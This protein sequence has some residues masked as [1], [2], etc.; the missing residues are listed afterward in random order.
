M[1]ERTGYEAVLGQ[2]RPIAVLTG[3]VVSQRVH[4]AYL[5]TGPDGVGKKRVA[6]AFAQALNCVGG[7]AETGVPC[8]VCRPCQKITQGIH[9]D[10]SMI[11]PD[12]TKARWVVKIDAVREITRQVTFKPY[13]GRRRVVMIDDAHTVTVEGGN[14]FL[15][16]L[17]EPTGDTVFVLLSS[18]P[19]ALLTTIRSRCQALRFAPLPVEVLRGVL[20]A[21][22]IEPELATLAASFSEGSVSRALALCQ[23][24]A[25]EVRKQLLEDVVALQGA[26]ALAVFD[27]ASDLARADADDLRARLDFLRIFL[28][29][30]MLCKSAVPG[31]RIANQD[32]L[33]RVERVADRMSLDTVV[34]HLDRISEVERGISHYVDARLLLEDL[35]FDM[36]GLPREG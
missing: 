33:D 35:L 27:M 4:H 32:L 24:G 18:Q 29:D 26:D 7:A 25:L 19:R 30:V 12:R 16:T 15:K 8:G 14:A 1:A 13:E 20:V 6:L 23:E 34:R 21:Q 28:R 10:V 3:A 22:G 11:E 17:E 2:S 36:A 9:P 5:F 31:E